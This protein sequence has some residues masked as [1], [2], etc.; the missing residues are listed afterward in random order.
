MNLRTLF[1]AGVILLKF[2]LSIVLL[3]FFCGACANMPGKRVSSSDSLNLLFSPQTTLFEMTDKSG[4]FD[5]SRESGKATDNRYVVKQQIR[6]PDGERK[7][8]EQS[9]SFSQIGK[10]RG[11][12]DILRPALSQY[13]VWFDGDRY[14]SELKTDVEKKSLVVNMVSPEPEWNGERTIPF[15]DDNAVYCYFSQLIECAFITGFIEKAIDKRAG[16]MNMIILWEGYPFYMQQ[17]PEIPQEPFTRAVLEFDGQTK[18]QGLRFSLRFSGQSIFYF[19]TKS[20]RYDRHFWVAQG[21]S[22][23]RKGS[24]SE[25]P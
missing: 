12:I 25:G 9:I 11:E 23:V 21:L 15:P 17:Y 22:V 13:T 1:W 24:S 4:R 8:L 3:L 10:L 16:S 7:V 19:V 18:D 2:K 6:L 14:F 20:G 5:F